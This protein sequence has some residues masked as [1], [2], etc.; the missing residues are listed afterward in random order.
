MKAKNILAVILLLLVGVITT[1]AENW[2][3][4]EEEPTFLVRTEDGQLWYCETMDKEKAL[5]QYKEYQEYLKDFFSL[6]W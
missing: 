3:E 1:S 5:E 6:Y 2:I 4:V